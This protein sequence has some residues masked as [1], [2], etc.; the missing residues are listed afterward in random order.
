[1]LLGSAGTCAGSWLKVLLHQIL[2]KCWQNV[3][4]LLTCYWPDIDQILTKYW[5]NIDQIL[6]CSIVKLFYGQVF[7]TGPTQWWLTF[8]GQ[9]VVAI[10]QIFILGIP[11]QVGSS[12]ITMLLLLLLLLVSMPRS[13]H[14]WL[15]CSCCYTV[16]LL[17]YPYV[18]VF[19]GYS[20]ARAVLGLDNMI[21]L[22]GR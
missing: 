22:C 9:T 11:A 2:T 21:G 13:Y 18:G 14:Q 8:V 5:Q 12:I 1:M 17:P 15:Q 3:D 20:G 4:K 7:S 19:S 16:K 6:H 10:S